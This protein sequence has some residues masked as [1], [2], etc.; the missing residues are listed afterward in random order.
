VT[1]AR[2]LW[3]LI[4]PIHA[5]TYFSPHAHQ[6]FESAGLRGFWRGYFAGRAAP[7]GAVEAGPVTALFFGFAPEFVARAVPEIWSMCE[8]DGAI[9]ARLAGV[10]AALAEL[11]GDAVASRDI[12]RAADLLPAACEPIAQDRRP[13]SAA[14]AALAWPDAPHLRLWH[15][16]TLLRE[17]R[18]DGHIVALA[19][20]E[21]GPCEAHVL[22]LAVSGAPAESIR[23]YRGWGEEDWANAAERLRSRGLLDGSGGP[24]DAGRELHR[25]VEVLTDR[26]AT[27][28]AEAVD[29]DRLARLLQPVHRSIAASGLI[30]YP[31]PMGLP[32]PP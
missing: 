9:A 2:R 19:V 11:L 29:P 23:P 15:A 14:N 8:P 20:A 27:V 16:S 4:E 3:S 1:P 21:L 7:L 25:S 13:M 31:N 12:E 5:L 10:D 6:A 26:L 22:R 32:P 17:H 28:P 30:P 18:G 24:T